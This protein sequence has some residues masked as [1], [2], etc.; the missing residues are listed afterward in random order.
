MQHEAI[1]GPVRGHYVVAYA[2]PGRGKASLFLGGFRV[3]PFRP[4]T[5]AA[6]G[7]VAEAVSP[8]RYPSAEVA[9]HHAGLKGTALAEQLACGPAP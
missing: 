1:I 4:A 7:H 2:A 6:P 9:L 8:A 5:A 3:Y